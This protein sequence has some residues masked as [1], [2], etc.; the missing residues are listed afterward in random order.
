MRIPFLAFGVVFTLA[1]DA[2]TTQPSL[3]LHVG[4]PAFECTDLQNPEPGCPVLW[5]SEEVT[6]EM[7]TLAGDA[8]GSEP[9]WTGQ[10]SEEI[11]GPLMCPAYVSLA[12]NKVYIPQFSETAVF[13][14][15]SLT[16]IRDMGV[17]QFGMPMAVYS[18]PSASI[19][20]SSP[21]LKYKMQGGEMHA[22]CAIIQVKTPFGFR[23]ELGPIT[24][25]NYTGSVYL[26]D[27]GTPGPGDFGGRGWGSHDTETSTTKGGGTIPA[28]A[29]DAVDRFLAGLGC[30]AGWEIWVDDKRACDA[31]GNEYDANGNRV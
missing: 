26:A 8:S 21:P 10:Y 17:S 22:R 19:Y 31:F 30:T 6:D 15:S 1:C 4:P 12:T 24:W 5:S 28:G 9:L 11:E 27:W 25:Y 7:A 20:S 13:Q 29:Q 18:V 3:A 23:V 16:K 14:V 2:S